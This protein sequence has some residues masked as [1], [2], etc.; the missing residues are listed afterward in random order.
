MVECF[1]KRLLR[2]KKRRVAGGSPTRCFNEGGIL[3]MKK[4]TILFGVLVLCFLTACKPN[5]VPDS[6][7]APEEGGPNLK[8]PA[9][10]G[11]VC[12]YQGSTTLLQLPVF[13]PEDEDF[14]LNGVTAMEISG[15]GVSFPC[16]SYSLSSFTECNYD[17][18]KTATLNFNVSLE[19]SGEFAVNKLSITSF[20]ENFT[21][22]LDL[23]RIVLD[24]REEQEPQTG[25]LSMRQF[26]VNQI[27]PSSLAITYMNHTDQEISIE[28]FTYPSD[29][30]SG[31]KIEKY[32]D[33]ELTAK[34]E[35]LTIPPQE[36]KTFL[37]TFEFEDNFAEN[38]GKFFYL[39]P[40]VAYEIE[41]EQRIMP[42]QTQ[43]TVVQTPFTETVMSEILN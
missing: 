24:I 7:A 35:G 28:S 9:F 34:E 10:S 15:D 14:S 11:Y 13:L 12:G 40:F 21:V 38:E 6:T 19:E 2:H 8:A 17:G 39:L 18:Y 27:D 3:F 29:I 30:C 22:E 1:H 42:A 32:D 25:D 31:V 26:W 33:F 16:S 36:E 4:F 5:A 43:A 41:G 37:V 23:G 20:S